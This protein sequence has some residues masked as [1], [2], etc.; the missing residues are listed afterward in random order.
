MR[1]PARCGGPQNFSMNGAVAQVIALALHGNAALLRGHSA[2]FLE[3]NSTAQFCQSIQFMRTERTW[4]GL[5]KRQIALPTP[6]DWFA[7]LRA[8]RARGIGVRW[9]GG[10]GAGVPDRLL[11]GFVGRGGTWILQVQLSDHAFERWLDRWLTDGASGRM[12][13]RIWRVAYRRADVGRA[14]LPVV[15]L[16]AAR[17]RLVRALTEIHAF[18]SRVDAKPFT[19]RFEKALAALAGQPKGEPY[20]RDLF[21]P[22]QVSA[23]TAAMIHAAQHAWVFGAM[24]SWNDLCFSGADGAEY[25]RV[26]EGLFQALTQFIPAVVGADG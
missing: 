22:G 26:S 17:A 2:D 19:E 21:P 14:A 24:G 11:A 3:Q 25:G 12:D 9:I 4:F 6:D 10:T 7:D 13:R 8:R 20:H 16:A 23:P 15:E 18:A 5:R 1:L